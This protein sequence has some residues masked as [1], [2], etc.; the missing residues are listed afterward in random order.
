MGRIEGQQRGHSRHRTV[1]LFALTSVVVALSSGV[2]AVE[3]QRVVAGTPIADISLTPAISSL[4]ITLEFARPMQ[5]TE[6]WFPPG[7]TVRGLRIIEKS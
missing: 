5:I 4:V 2:V 3:S 7:S 1:P 6:V